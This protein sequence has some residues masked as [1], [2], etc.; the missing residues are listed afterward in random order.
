M[1]LKNLIK[2]IILEYE[3]AKYDRMINDNDRIEYK[4]QV[5]GIGYKMYIKFEDNFEYSTAFHI[6]END[7]YSFETKKDISHLNSVLY[8]VHEILVKEVKDKKIRF[9]SF[10]PSIRKGE[11]LYGMN[12]RGKI[13][14]RFF[15]KIYPQEA[16]KKIINKKITIDFTKVYPEIFE[17]DRINI[18]KKM[19]EKIFIDVDFNINGQNENIF[20]ISNTNFNIDSDKYNLYCLVNTEKTKFLINIYK[21]DKELIK[22]DFDT[23]EDL[24]NFFTPKKK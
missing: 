7:N 2:K 23:F 1:I 17:N 24:L 11:N 10:S 21:N 9:I 19:I 12:S 6:D 4:F 8:T 16:L 14:I 20:N 5:N 15:K 3:I 18:L 22:K 13:Y